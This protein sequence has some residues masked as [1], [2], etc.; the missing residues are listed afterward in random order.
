VIEVRVE[1]RAALADGA[2]DRAAIADFSDRYGDLSLEPV[3]VVI[4]AFEEERAIG[5]VLRRVPPT[6]VGLGVSKLVV[7][8]GGADDTAG[9]AE[10]AGALVCRCPVN[11]GQ[12]AALR[13][14]Y[15]LARERGATYIVVVDAD[16]QWDPAEAE[17]LLRLIVDGEA[18]FV[19]GSRRLGHAHD[20]DRVRSVGVVVFAFLVR[21]L[22]NTRVTDTSSGLRAFPAQL[23]EGLLL[24]QDQYQASELLIGMIARGARVAEVPVTMDPRHAGH[25]KKGSN[26]VYGAHYAR[27]VLRTWWRE[28]ATLRRR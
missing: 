28:R 8:D 2:V 23:T 12:G 14:G 3:C 27:V 7:V 18:D 9:A 16:G 26:L 10:R 24:E 25:S 20:T 17:T 13:L 4:P 6:M 1:P 21:L 22:T 15:R 11:R 5:A 19:Q